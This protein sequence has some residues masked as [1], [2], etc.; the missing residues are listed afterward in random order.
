[1]NIDI[2]INSIPPA[3]FKKY[4]LVDVREDQELAHDPSLIECAH[5]P[6][7]KAPDNFTFF[8]NK[9]ET[10]LIFCHMGGRSHQLADYLTS[11]GYKALSVNYGVGALNNYLSQHGLAK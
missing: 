8:N 2:D 10:Y 9:E 6:L 11:Q 3:E 5:V 4:K 1:M 7:S